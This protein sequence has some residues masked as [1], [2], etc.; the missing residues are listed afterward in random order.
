[1]D[2]ATR[3]A[4]LVAI[5]AAYAAIRASMFAGELHFGNLA[6]VP[7]SYLY[8]LQVGFAPHAALLYEPAPGVWLSVPRLAFTATAIA[9]LVLAAIPVWESIRKRLAFW[10]GWAFLG[11]LP[12]ANVV[13][14]ETQ[15]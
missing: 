8:L 7:L 6:L 14:Q 13:Q 9:A 4:P 2:F 11:L 12:A 10:S 15:F 5:A 1:R 3:A